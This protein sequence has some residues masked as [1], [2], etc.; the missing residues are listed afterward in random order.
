M[1]A[2]QP[3]LQLAICAQQLARLQAD[4]LELNSDSAEE[5]CWTPVPRPRAAIPFSPM[6]AAV[7]LECAAAVNLLS[8]SIR[9]S[10]LKDAP[11]FLPLAAEGLP[12]DASSPSNT[13]GLCLVGQLCTGLSVL[14]SKAPLQVQAI[15]CQ[16]SQLHESLVVH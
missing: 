9:D 13:N 2:A 5:V 14:H 6:V 4:S 10:E 16:L 11:M 8:M 1:N 3:E 15:A 12:L 7:G